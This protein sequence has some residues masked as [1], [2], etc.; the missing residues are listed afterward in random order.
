MLE[1]FT[2]W[3]ISELHTSSLQLWKG[4]SLMGAPHGILKKAVEQSKPDKTGPLPRALKIEVT[5]EYGSGKEKIARLICEMLKRDLIYSK[6]VTI[7]LRAAQGFDGNPV[8]EGPDDATFLVL[9][10]DGSPETP[11]T[12]D[13]FKVMAD[14]HF[15]REP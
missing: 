8:C 14:D 13:A 5:G 9:V 10:T 11:E 1:M 3:K 7:Q 4:A 6:R 2:L 12:E 15:L